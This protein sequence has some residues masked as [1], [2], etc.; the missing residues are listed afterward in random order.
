MQTFQPG[1]IIVVN[2][3]GPLEHWGVISDRWVDGMPCVISCSFR[4]GCVAEE[5]FKEFAGNNE[6]RIKEIPTVLSPSAI[7]TRARSRVGTKYNIFTWN[8]EHFV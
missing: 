1:T 5:S 4:Q 7:I 8:C 2:I 6:V 3:F